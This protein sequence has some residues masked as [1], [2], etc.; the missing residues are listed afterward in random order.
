VDILSVRDVQ[1]RFGKATVLDSCSISIKSAEVVGLIGP[2]GSGKSTLLNVINGYYD[3]DAGTV[4]LGERDITN[5]KPFEIA[6]AGVGR[7]FQTPRLFRELSV[8]ENLHVVASWFKGAQPVELKAKALL[9]E[10]GIPQHLWSQRAGALSGGQQRL[11]ELAMAMMHDPRLLLLDEPLA[12]LHPTMIKTIL[13]K[14]AALKTTRSLAIILVSHS[15]PPILPVV[16]RLVVL[17]AG[18]ILVEGLPESVIGDRR[19]IDAYLGA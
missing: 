19:V 1:K 5:R 7:T 14:I 10:S 9:E 12:G 16:D 2:N 15:I 11:V 18:A 3:C 6:R 4:S 13:D 17:V 8:L